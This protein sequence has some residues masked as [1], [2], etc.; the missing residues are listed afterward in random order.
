[1]SRYTRQ[2]LLPEVGAEGQGRL[3]SAHVLV[4]GAGGL[5]AP[6][7]PLLAG[8]GVGRITIVDGDTVDLSNLHR[9]TLFAEADCGHPKAERAADRCRAL[10]AEVEVVA[11][12][13]ALTSENAASLVAQADVV[14]DCADSYAASYIL[15]DTCLAQGKPLI[16]ASVLGLSG[17]VGGFCGGAPSLRAVFP[18]APDS[19]ASCATAGVLGPVV[20]VIGAMQAQMALNLILG[21]EPSPLGQIV[22]YDAQTLRSTGFRFDDAPEPN[23]CFRFL[24]VNQLT[25]ADQIVELRGIEEAPVPAHPDAIR[26]SPENLQQIDPNKGKRLALCCA[27]GLRSWRA[28]EHM[29]PNWPGEIVL[30]AASTS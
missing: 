4:V 8:A 30:V 29:Q 7:L 11:L 5:A 24:S 12:N 22:Q 16:S 19:G 25:D 15:S 14:L 13:H 27:T 23:T 21:L 10:N 17:Y 18:D 2:T 28:A 20:G 6:V 3:S 9:Q 1:M 26:I